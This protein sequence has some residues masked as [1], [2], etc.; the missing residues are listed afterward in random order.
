MK[1]GGRVL[2][3]F[4]IIFAIL[5]VIAFIGIN[6]I[7][8]QV[9]EHAS[10]LR[11]KR[12]ANWIGLKTRDLTDKERFAI[13]VNEHEEAFQ[14]GALIALVAGSLSTLGGTILT[15]LAFQKENESAKGKC[16]GERQA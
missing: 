15:L 2:L 11:L 10:Q 12:A 3:I 14:T 1:H 13:Y 9:Q 16:K 8:G 7:D 5:G 6:Y 4:G